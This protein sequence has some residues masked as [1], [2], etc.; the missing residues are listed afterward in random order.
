MKRYRI[1]QR[2]CWDG[3]YYFIQIRSLF[4]WVDYQIK[5]AMGFYH[6]QQYST[7]EE[8]IE[9]VKGMKGENVKPHDTVIK[10]L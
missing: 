9:A 1:I 3:K 2:H 4:S 8:A 7:Q 6:P 10:Y 5:D